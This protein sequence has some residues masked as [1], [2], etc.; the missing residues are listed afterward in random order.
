MADSRKEQIMNDLENA[1]DLC[2]AAEDLYAQFNFKKSL[3]YFQNG[4]EILMSIKKSTKDDK[5][6]NKRIKNKMGKG[7]VIYMCGFT[8]NL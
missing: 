8:I 2:D 4:L 1:N 3:E 5:K 6:F 7:L